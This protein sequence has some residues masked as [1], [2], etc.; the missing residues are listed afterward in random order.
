M[1]SAGSQFPIYRGQEIYRDTACNLLGKTR[2]VGLLS[3]F[4]QSETKLQ[5]YQKVI[6]FSKSVRIRLFLVLS[7]SDCDR[8][9]RVGYSI[10]G[11][12][13]WGTWERVLR[14][15]SLSIL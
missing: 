10:Q 12:V 7:R 2:P 3:I 4:G 1:R 6:I 15:S 11:R 9:N 13:G 8:S 5:L 14:V